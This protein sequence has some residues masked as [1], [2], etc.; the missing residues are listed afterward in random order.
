MKPYGRKD[1]HH[2]HPDIH[3]PKGWVNWWETELKDVSKKRE[4]RKNKLK[5]GITEA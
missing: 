4:R 5:K 3:P 2:N 1:C